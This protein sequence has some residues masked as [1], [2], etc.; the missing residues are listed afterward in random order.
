ME[1]ASKMRYPLKPSDILS[2][3]NIDAGRKNL[4]M[5]YMDFVQEINA[6]F[7]TGYIM[8]LCKDKEEFSSITIEDRIMGIFLAKVTAEEFY[9]EEEV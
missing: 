7:Y 8:A 6:A 1:E 9:S 5:D 2:Q 3:A 4:C